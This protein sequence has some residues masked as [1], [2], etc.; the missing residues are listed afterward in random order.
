MSDSHQRE[1]ERA[2]ALGDDAARAKLLAERVRSGSLDPARLRLAAHL[3]DSAARTALDGEAPAVIEALGSWVGALGAWGRPLVVR[4]LLVA[5]R[6]VLPIFT[7]ALPHEESPERALRGAE[8]WLQEPDEATA[9]EAERASHDAFAC[10]QRVTQWLCQ[11]DR[12]ALFTGQQ[13]VALEY[14]PWTARDAALGAFRATCRGEDPEVSSLLRLD[15][16]MVG[17]GWLEEGA[18]RAAIRGALVPLA[19]G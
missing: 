7:A 14:V 12:L 10:V 16:S 11:R 2:A 15:A 3:G 19:L 8:A 17:S 13:R 18:L 1:L 6:R 9:L 5:T 4:S